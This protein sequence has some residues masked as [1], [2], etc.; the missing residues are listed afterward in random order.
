MLRIHLLSSIHSLTRSLAHHHHRQRSSAKFFVR[1]HVLLSLQTQHNTQT[2]TF[3]AS[4]LIQ[5]HTHTQQQIE[6]DVARFWIVLRA[7]NNDAS[8]IIAYG[9]HLSPSI[10]FCWLF[11]GSRRTRPKIRLLIFSDFFQV[12]FLLQAFFVLFHGKVSRGNYYAIH[13][14]CMHYASCLSHH[15]WLLLL[16]FLEN[17]V[18]SPS[19]DLLLFCTQDFDS[20]RRIS[21]EQMHTHT[22]RHTPEG[23][24][25]RRLRRLSENGTKF[26][27][28]HN[29]IS[30]FSLNEL[31]RTWARTHIQR[32]SI[33][34]YKNGKKKKE[35]NCHV[36]WLSSGC[37]YLALFVLLIKL[38]SQLSSEDN[39]NNITPLKLNR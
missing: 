24:K 5:A 39:N 8:Q 31:I 4:N 11:F 19:L 38:I 36:L 12:V 23:E 3:K 6:H 22:E 17:I 25:S 29:S 37:E 15:L 1:A 18:P 13:T 10:S 16:L 20:I 21:L 28:T 7:H 26:T 2:H 34:H 35:K 33:E 30:M 27:A 9:I 14:Q 32:N